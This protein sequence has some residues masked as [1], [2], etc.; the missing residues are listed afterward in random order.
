M[1]KRERTVDNGL[2]SKT[3][4]TNL[5]LNTWKFLIFWFKKI[6]IFICIYG[7]II[8]SLYQFTKNKVPLMQ[9]VSFVAS[10]KLR[11]NLTLF[12]FLAVVISLT[13]FFPFSK[14]H[15]PGIFLLLIQQM[16]VKK[17]IFVG[18]FYSNREKKSK[19]WKAETEQIKNILTQV[20]NRAREIKGW[21]RKN[22]GM[23]GKTK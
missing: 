14:S 13:L 22:A 11:E 10:M 6:W 20:R 18:L 21:D 3:V 4:M 16:I 12:S 7:C 2:F 19:E 8:S 23:N 15:H 1:T 17:Y 5:I 9:G